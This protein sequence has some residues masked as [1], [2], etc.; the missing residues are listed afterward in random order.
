MRPSWTHLALICS[1]SGIILVLAGFSWNGWIATNSPSLWYRHGNL[2][3]GPPPA[4][5]LL[6][7]GRAGAHRESDETSM[8]TKPWLQIVQILITLALTVF[9]TSLCLLVMLAMNC[10]LT[11]KMVLT[12]YVFLTFS[13]AAILMVPLVLAIVYLQ[14]GNMHKI[15]WG[16]YVEW[17][18]FL[19]QTAAAVFGIME[20]LTHRESLDETRINVIS[21][22]E[23]FYQGN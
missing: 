8:D 1:V 15:T 21:H 7:H 13:G 6:T 2:T 10:V 17:G 11:P 23:S 18:A 3:T 20:R 4:D 16:Y 22:T 5:Y 19:V 14:Q 12:V 9:V